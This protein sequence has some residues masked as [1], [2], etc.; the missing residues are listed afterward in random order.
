MTEY[1]FPRE[2]FN[3]TGIYTGIA[4]KSQISELLKEYHYLSKINNGFRIGKD[5][6]YGLYFKDRDGKY[7]L[8]GCCVYHTPSVQQT[9]KGMFADKSNEVSVLEMGR[10]CLNPIYHHKNILSWFVSKTLKD[11]KNKGFDVILTYADMDY[12]S[13]KIYQALSFD[14]YGL[15][16]P[17]KDFWFLLEDGTYK[18]H[19]R[20]SV[21]GRDGEW[22]DRSQ[23]HRYVKYLN[24]K[25]KKLMKWDKK[26]YSENKTLNEAPMNRREIV[27]HYCGEVHH[28]QEDCDLHREL[29]EEMWS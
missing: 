6:G 9:V 22:R 15:S 26:H 14:Y 29:L 16:A 19:Q 13:G 5:L 4:T 20:G 21:K 27:C 12:H 10:L 8:V 24:K 2:E 3:H 25:K 17:K 28:D 1:I 11:L 18:K 7:T 23:K